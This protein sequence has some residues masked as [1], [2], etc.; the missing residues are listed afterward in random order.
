MASSW[1]EKRLLS[2]AESSTFASRKG[3]K[4]PSTR[5]DDVLLNFSISCS[6]STMSFT[7]TDWTRPADNDGRTLRH[8]TGDS[9]KPT[10]RS[11]TRRACWAFTKSMSNVR[12]CANASSIADLVIS[13][14]TIRFTLAG[15]ILVTSIRC[16]E[17]ASPSRSSSV[18]NQIVSAS[19]AFFLMSLMSAFLSSRT[20]YCGSK[21][22]AMSI[23][24][25]FDGRSRTC[26]LLEI[27]V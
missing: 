2:S 14:K 27:T 3:V 16:H 12:G 15:S 13:W 18:A 17:M 4:T 25:P 5:N 6:R 21:S 23:P 20:S 11:S 8:S 22:W 24:M 7:A 19:A 26:P 9:S 1:V 10:R